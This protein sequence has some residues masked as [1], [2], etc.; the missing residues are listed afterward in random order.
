M[1]TPE[2]KKPKATAEQ[3]AQWEKE[4]AEKYPTHHGSIFD[5]TEIMNQ[6]R[7]YVAGRQAAFDEYE[8]AIKSR[9]IL[10]AEDKARIAVLESLLRDYVYVGHASMWYKRVQ[11]A[12]SGTDKQKPDA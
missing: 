4:A 12:L 10:Q 5:W 9:N 7:A 1:T 6:R 3:I 8:D 2:D 11:S